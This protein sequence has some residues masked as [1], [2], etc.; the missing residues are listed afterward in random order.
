MKRFLFV[1][2]A[3]L[4]L[5]AAGQRPLFSEIGAM[6]QSLSE[7]TGL[8]FLHDVPY[9]MLNKDQL[10]RYLDDRI[11][12]AIKPSDLRA[13]ELTLKMLGLIPQDFDLRQ[14]TVDL[15]TEQAAAFYDYNKKR[16]FILEG[17][18]AS[19]DE[20]IA[21]VHELAHA[22]ADQHFHLGRYIHEGARS[23]DG[24]TARLAV[25]EGQASWLMTAYMSKLNGGP[26][27]APD[28]MLD[29]MTNSIS[30]SAEQYPVFAKAPLYIRE[31]LVFPYTQGMLFQNAL[32][33]KL[34]RDSFAEVFRNP[35]V[36]TQQILHPEKYLAHRAP[37]LPDPPEVPE[38]RQFRKL[39]EGS[40]GELDLRVLLSQYAGQ[41]EGSKAAAHLDGGS[42]QLLEHKHAKY[43]VL[44]FA[45]TWDSED[46]AL[47]YVSLYRRVMQ[48]KWKT[49]QWESDTA[50]KLEGRG[51]SGRFR[52]W[53]E[54]N[55]VRQLE[56]LH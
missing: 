34:G 46:A 47:K 32:F 43:P 31:S 37:H 50:S 2:L 41:D 18:G 5:R 11:K 3:A 49:I 1:L 56:G 19:S 13:E 15:L 44:A 30:T 45:S 39:A 26:P 24:S 33:R 17:S 25:M 8:R 12:K 52:L 51:D 22:L 48:G 14:S 4:L 29:L 7:I 27:E 23:D 55:T 10:R 20:R 16:L 40:L 21:L 28:K 6:E 53:I 54:G 35:P 42:Y 9:G 36:S 38:S